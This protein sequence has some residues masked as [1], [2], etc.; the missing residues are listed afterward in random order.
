MAGQNKKTIIVNKET[1]KEELVPVIKDTE[2][3]LKLLADSWRMAQID[4]NSSVLEKAAKMSK[5]RYLYI[6]G[7]L[8][9]FE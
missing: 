4:K 5:D 3:N 1:N 7:N 2:K 8:Y 6:L 9:L